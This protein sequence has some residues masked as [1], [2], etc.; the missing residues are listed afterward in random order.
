MRGA[1]WCPGGN[2]VGTGDGV[3]GVL[4]GRPNGGDGD[5]SSWTASTDVVGAGRWKGDDW[6]VESCKHGH[7]SASYRAPDDGG[8]QARGIL[9]RLHGVHTYDE[10]PVTTWSRVT[11]VDAERAAVAESGEGGC[12]DWLCWLV[13][14]SSR[15]ALESCER[16]RMPAT[17]DGTECGCGTWTVGIVLPGFFFFER[18][19]RRWRRNV[20]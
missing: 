8:M 11:S 19:W 2:Q 13:V 10:V 4:A 20:R 16:A 5:C 1:G 7:M 18:R 12:P 6:T 17:Y 15:L 9:A 14:F 3:V